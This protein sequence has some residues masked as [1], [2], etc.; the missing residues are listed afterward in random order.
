M[1][2][3]LLSV[4]KYSKKKNEVGVNIGDYIQALASS[5]FYPSIDGFIDRDEEL[6][7]YNGTP[8][9][10]IMNGWFMHNP[11]CWPPSNKITPLFVAFHINSVAMEPM[12]SLES[13]SY[14]AEHA[15]I[16][17]R[18]TKTA[19]ILQ[20][21]GVDSYFSGCMTL[22]LGQKYHSTKKDGTT[23]IVDPI[24]DGPLS[25]ENIFKALGVVLLHPRDIFSLC[26]QKKLNLQHGRNAV[27]NLLKVALYYKEYSRMFTRDIVMNSIYLYHESAR[28]N[29]N[30]SD[31]EFLDMA[32][33]LV[34]LYAKARLVITSRIHCALPCLGLETP[35]IYIEKYNDSETSACR[36]GGLSAL[37]NKAVMKSG[38]LSFDFDSAVPLTVVPNNKDTWRS[39]AEKLIDRCRDFIK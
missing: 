34:K 5:Q 33:S 18:D 17:C 38:T 20:A 22:T 13:L 21:H 14:L 2:F 39:L 1:T 15:P 28:Y 4:S 30:Y 36:L 16:G 11:A 10:M 3:K 7:S 25:L 9:K 29:D 27:K 23:Y 26:V 6:H 19:E 31:S 35:V 8:C 24:D 12:L 32:E 37:F